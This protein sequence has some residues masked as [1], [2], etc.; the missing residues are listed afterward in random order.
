MG[1]AREQAKA[2]L[3]NGQVFNNRQAFKHVVIDLDVLAMQIVMH[4]EEQM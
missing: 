2:S 1:D 4:V 3:A